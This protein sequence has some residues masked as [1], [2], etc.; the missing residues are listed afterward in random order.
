MEING[1][2]VRNLDL[3]KPLLSTRLGK[4]T[5]AVIPVD[6]HHATRTTSNGAIQ[7]D[8]SRVRKARDLF[9]RV[10]FRSILPTLKY[11]SMKNTLKDKKIYQGHDWSIKLLLTKVP[12]NLVPL[13]ND[14][15][16]LFRLE[17]L[18]VLD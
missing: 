4:L 17:G 12:A 2:K 3:V 10:S 9:S 16:L 15:L 5:L 6:S 11:F 1:N 18:P 8:A 13:V 14:V 7:P